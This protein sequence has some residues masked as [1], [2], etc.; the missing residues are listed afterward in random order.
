MLVGEDRKSKCVLMDV[1]RFQLTN[2]VPL[3]S[4]NK[5]C[6]EN[7]DRRLDN[8]CDLHFQSAYR[9]PCFNAP[10]AISTTPRP[11][12]QLRSR[13]SH[14]QSYCI[15]GPWASWMSVSAVVHVALLTASGAGVLCSPRSQSTA[16]RPGREVT[17]DIYDASNLCN[18]D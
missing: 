4:Q 6:N 5:S 2:I 7:S 12:A 9:P 15:A 17:T 18:G 8:R 10:L 14:K 16:V 11:S 3:L 13:E 1:H